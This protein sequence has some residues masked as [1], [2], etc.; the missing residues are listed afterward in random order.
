MEGIRNSVL[1]LVSY[2]IKA[3]SKGWGKGSAAAFKTLM[4]IP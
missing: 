3:L 1:I 4:K 2:R